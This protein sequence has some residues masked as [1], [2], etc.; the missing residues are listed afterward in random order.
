MRTAVI[1]KGKKLNF[2]F[3]RD[4]FYRI[5]EMRAF[6]AALSEKRQQ[7]LNFSAAVR[8]RKLPWAKVWTEE[9]FPLLLYAN[10]HQLPDEDEFRIMPEGHPVDAELRLRSEEIV[11]FQITMAYAE[12]NPPR[13]GGYIASMEREGANQATPV[14]LGGKIY[15]GAGDRISSE[16]RLL[17]PDIDRCAWRLGLLNAVKKKIDKGAAYARGV[18]CLLVY[19]E[20]LWFIMGYENVAPVIFSAIRDALP[21]TKTLPFR[22]LIVLDQPRSAL[23]QLPEAYVLVSNLL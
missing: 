11:R 16:P 4:Q 17:S 23:N 19:A 12:W 14:F 3:C 10:H 8:N 20:R 7:D 13:S 2:S 18:D 1:S 21:N 5:G 22:Q 15:K 6:Q 9:V